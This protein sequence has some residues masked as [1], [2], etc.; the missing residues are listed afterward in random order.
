MNYIW[1]IY[2]FIKKIKIYNWPT[3]TKT[4]R[5]A[6]ENG[7][8]HANLLSNNTSFGS[9]RMHD[10]EKLQFRDSHLQI[11]YI[12]RMCYLFRYDFLSVIYQNWNYYIICYN[13]DIK[14]L[15]HTCIF[16]HS[17]YNIIKYI[18]STYSRLIHFWYTNIWL[19]STT[20]PRYN[21]SHQRFYVL[22]NLDACNEQLLRTG[23]FNYDE[24]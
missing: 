8:L 1:L 9:A 10:Y 21:K 6:N 18:Y 5:F 2:N 7:Y 13:V 22:C 23:A 4:Y 14:F 3:L 11:Y 12:W 15:L 16:S 20:P 17:T 19:N 24:K